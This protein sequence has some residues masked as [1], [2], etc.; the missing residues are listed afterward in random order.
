MSEGNKDSYLGEGR[1]KVLDLRGHR[2]GEVTV[3][4]LGGRNTSGRIKWVCLCDC[5]EEFSVTGNALR[6]GNTKSCGCK[7]IRGKHG[8]S[9]SLEYKAWNSARDRTT[10]PKSKYYYAYGGRGIDFCPTWQ[11]FKVFIKDM[12]MK[13]TE[14]HSLE[15]VDN[16]KGYNKDNCVWAT[17]S[18]QNF[19]RRYFTESNTGKVG[20]HLCQRDKVYIA[21]IGVRGD[22]IRVG[23]FSC[24]EEAYKARQEAEKLYYGVL[25]KDV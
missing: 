3:K 9:K 15:R 6:N 16:N 5:G 1:K 19:N 18:E 8:L 21:H 12:G 17:G 10:N 25:Y 20:V 13:P 23:R 2:Y 22:R 4:E 24:L 14:K 11:D 7:K